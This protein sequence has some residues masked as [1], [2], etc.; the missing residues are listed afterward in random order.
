MKGTSNTILGVIEGFYGVFYTF[1]ERDDL[2]QFIGQHGYNYYLYAPK[3]DRQHRARWR[4]DYPANI[5]AQFAETTRLAE[6]RGVTFAYGISPGG[7]VCYACPADFDQITRKFQAFYEAGVRAFSLMLD[8][9][10]PGFRFATDQQRYA[11]P[12]EAQADLANRLYGWLQTLDACNTLTVCPADYS[13]RAPFSRTLNLLGGELHPDIDL[14]YTGPEICSPTITAGDARQFADAAF[15]K[16]I[17]WDN[18]PVNDLGMQGELHMGPVTG[19]AKD[20]RRATRGILANPM[21]QAEA[22]KIPLLT[23]ADYWFSPT[24][25]Q[26]EASWQRALEQVAGKDSAAAVRIVAENSSLSCLPEVNGL[27]F[28]Q[29]LAERGAAALAALEQ[30]E[31]AQRSTALQVLEDYLS[32]IDEGTYHVKFRLENLAL[33]NNLLPWVEVLEH[34]MWMT[35]FALIV[36]RAIEK[37]QPYMG[38]LKRVNEYREAIQSH[39]KKV[40]GQSLLPLVDYVIRRV[41]QDQR[42]RVSTEWQVS[43]S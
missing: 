23:L 18:Y 3:N 25:Y 21:I 31:S 30:G 35:R 28:G 10:T 43:S 14:F 8:D 17:I 26:P 16:P 4:E 39:P 6:Q 33:R 7:D 13:G 29:T 2:I 37:G 20:L 41:E 42:R 22:S 36:L 5:M 24:S 12:A 40:A 15:R 27:A 9:N 1:P 32:E 19:R 34:W 11:T 38:E